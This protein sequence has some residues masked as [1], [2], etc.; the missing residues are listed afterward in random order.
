MAHRGKCIGMFNHVCKGL[1]KYGGGA[2]MC[3]LHPSCKYST[4][5]KSELK[6]KYDVVIIGAGTYI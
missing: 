4:T 3:D 6:P 5:L 2:P 1:S